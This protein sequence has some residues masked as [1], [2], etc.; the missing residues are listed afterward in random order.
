MEQRRKNRTE[1]NNRATRRKKAAHVR[2]ASLRG[3]K[4]ERGRERE[5]GEKGKG[6]DKGREEQENSVAFFLFMR[7][8][9]RTRTR[10]PTC[11]VGAV[12]HRQCR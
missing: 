9:T 2:A 4:R 3:H 11:T 8:K 10:N 12:S 1:I 7:L 5:R 6:R